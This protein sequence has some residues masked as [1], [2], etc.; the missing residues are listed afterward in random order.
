[1]FNVIKI[2]KGQSQTPTLRVSPAKPNYLSIFLEKKITPVGLWAHC[3]W[4][5]WDT[6]IQ[7]SGNDDGSKGRFQKPQSRRF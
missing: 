3:R 7:V 5:T 4:G 2:L 6:I 1:M